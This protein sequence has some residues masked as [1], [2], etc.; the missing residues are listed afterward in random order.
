MVV[1][2][3]DVDGGCCCCCLLLL[4]AVEQPPSTGKALGFTMPDTVPDALS[5]LGF[6][7]S[8]K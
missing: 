7:V 2:G 3:V 6:L 1:G 5:Y 4:V 8:A